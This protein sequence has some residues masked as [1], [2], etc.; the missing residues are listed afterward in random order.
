MPIRPLSWDVWKVIGYM[1][2]EFRERAT[3]RLIFRSVYLSHTHFASPHMNE[4]SDGEILKVCGWK[5]FSVQNGSQDS[6]QPCY[7]FCSF[8]FF[9]PPEGPSYPLPSQWKYLV[10]HKRA[11]LLLLWWNNWLFLSLKLYSFIYLFG[12]IVFYSYHIKIRLTCLWTCTS[13][14]C[15]LYR[16]RNH[17]LIIFLS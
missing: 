10:I 14:H 13:P 7:Y 2:L 16:E 17:A 5:F 1:N 6:L 15:E 9:F 11:W 4:Y 8:V 3:W 12:P